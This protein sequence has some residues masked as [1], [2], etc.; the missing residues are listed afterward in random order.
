M[1]KLTI[2]QKAQQIIAFDKEI[3]GLKAIFDTPTKEISCIDL[4]C[5]I[6]KKNSV[7]SMTVGIT[8]INALKN[9]LNDYVPTLIAKR[10][11]F[12]HEINQHDEAINS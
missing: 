6:R 10:D 3:K 11:K 12:E 4:G 7:G 1:E 8:D 2:A 9:F 5:V